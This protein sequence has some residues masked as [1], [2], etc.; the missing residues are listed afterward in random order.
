[1][2]LSHDT[3]NDHLHNVETDWELKTPSENTSKQILVSTYHSKPLEQEDG[4]SQKLRNLI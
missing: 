3:H 4:A 2:V 1:M